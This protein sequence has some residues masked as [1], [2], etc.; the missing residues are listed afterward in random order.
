M[1]GL[2]S[3]MR[4]RAVSAWIVPGYEKKVAGDGSGTAFAV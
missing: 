3:T 4:N 2:A 1:C